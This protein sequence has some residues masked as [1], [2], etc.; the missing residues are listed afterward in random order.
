MLF[1]YF[2]KETGLD[3]MVQIVTNSV[4]NNF[5]AGKMVEAKYP[6]IYWT[7]CAVHCIDLMLEDNF[8]VTHL[9]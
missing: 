9:K 6:H 7:L 1:D 3:H 8:K 5:L 4:A 2:I